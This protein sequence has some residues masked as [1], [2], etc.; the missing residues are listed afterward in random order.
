[1][2]CIYAFKL[3]EQRTENRENTICL[4]PSCSLRLTLIGGRDDKT[5]NNRISYSP[6]PA[7][8]DLLLC[9]TKKAKPGS[10]ETCFSVYRLRTL[11]LCRQAVCCFCNRCENSS[12]R[13]CH[14]QYLTSSDNSPRL[15]EVVD[16]DHNPTERFRGIRNHMQE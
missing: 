15:S 12:G 1:M 9:R 14:Q 8:H 4:D 2:K 5:G 11:P 3:E 7:N 16:N 13:Y 10:Y 6:V